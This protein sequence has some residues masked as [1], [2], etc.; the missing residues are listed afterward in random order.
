MKTITLAEQP[1]VKIPNRNGLYHRNIVDKSIGA[2][3]FTFHYAK[4]EEGGFGIAH[5]HPENEHFL[6][7]ISGELEPR[8]EQESHRVPAGTGIFVYPGEVHEV[9]NVHKG[10]TEY[11]VM[12]SPPREEK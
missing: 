11:Y 6:L 4:M 7:V 1:L 12:Y 5:S 2:Q 8:N 9:I 3:N 10:P